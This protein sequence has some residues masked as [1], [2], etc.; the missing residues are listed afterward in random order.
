[1]WTKQAGVKD[2]GTL[3]GPGSGAQASNDVGQ[4]VGEADTPD[5]NSHAFAYTKA[6][7]MQDLGTLGGSLS[8]AGAINRNSD[9][10]AFNQI[11]GWSLIPGDSVTHAVT[12][13]SG[14]DIA[15]LGTLG[16]NSYANGNN[17]VQQVVG[18]SDTSG[19]A[20]DAFLWDWV[21]GMQ[22]LGTLGG[23]FAQA[24]A[25]NCSGQIVGFSTLVGELQTDAF[26]NANGSMKDLEIR[27]Q[28]QSSHCNQ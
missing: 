22:D 7:G 8:N 19:G 4:I 20:T 12:W 13:D 6:A 28:C 5:S 10:N 3:G 14:L 26:L 27:S 24:N 16:A 11:A 21:N 25:I 17:C 23:N 9:T 1:L 15:D 18:A 2:L